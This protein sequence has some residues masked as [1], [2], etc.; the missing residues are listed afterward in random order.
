MP[1]APRLPLPLPPRSPQIVRGKNPLHESIVQGW[2]HAPTPILG[3]PGRVRHQSRVGH[4]S[5][6]SIHVRPFALPLLA[7]GCWLIRPLLTSVRSRHAL[8]RSALR[9]LAPFAASFARVDRQPL[10]T[11]GPCSTS[12][13]VWFITVQGSDAAAPDRSPRISS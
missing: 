3:S 7:R 6:L 4:R 5:S 1:G 2:L 12:G 9:R 13:P 11:P 10:H 8:L